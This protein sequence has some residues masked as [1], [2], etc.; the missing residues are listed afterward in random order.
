[1]AAE[2][3]IKGLALIR[4]FTPGFVVS[5]VQM[6]LFDGFEVLERVRRDLALATTPIILLT[7]LQDRHHMRQGMTI[8]A[9][10]YLTTPFAP[11]ELREAVSA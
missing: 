2:N 4:E 9:D 1:M 8:G 10:D 5:D 6:P 3:G 11:Q 7:S